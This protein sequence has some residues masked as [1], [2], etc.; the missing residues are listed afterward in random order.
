MGISQGLSAEAFLVVIFFL[1]PLKPL[2]CPAL[3]Q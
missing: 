1:W 2:G 3:V